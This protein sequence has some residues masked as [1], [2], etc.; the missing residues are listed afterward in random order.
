MPQDSGNLEQLVPKAVL[1]DRE[2]RSIMQGDIPPPSPVLTPHVQYELG[3]VLIQQGLALF[4]EN[5]GI[6]GSVIQQ[7][8]HSL[9]TL[10]N[11]SRNR[12]V[13]F[14]PIPPTQ[15]PHR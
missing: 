2:V 8:F 5:P 13:Y 10:I 15:E 3:Q 14:Y 9:E 7:H 11:K 6:L 4:K 1:S 12:S